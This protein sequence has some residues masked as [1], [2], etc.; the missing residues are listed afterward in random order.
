MWALTA[1]ITILTITGTDLL[2]KIINVTLTGISTTFLYMSVS[3]ENTSIKKYQDELEELDIQLKLALINNW[4]KKMD[5]Q[6]KD[7]NFELIY[8]SIS[9]SCQQISSSVYSINSKI[10][11][12][13]SKW[14]HNWR[15]F[16]LD[17]EIKL[18]KKQTNI[19]NNRLNLINFKNNL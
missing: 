11:N 6:E 7:S 17:E 18:I 8:K 2:G 15:T 19:L 13:F 9:E 10:E 4:I 12:H 1:P 5:L 16:D 3:S 14:F